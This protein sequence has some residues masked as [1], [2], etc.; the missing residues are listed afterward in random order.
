MES[1]NHSHIQKENP[2]LSFHLTCSGLHM[3]R[4]LTRRF[5]PSVARA[6]S[7]RAQNGY[8]PRPAN[9]SGFPES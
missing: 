7:G 2:A 1:A 3:R 8:L 4:A 9:S 6:F 5:F